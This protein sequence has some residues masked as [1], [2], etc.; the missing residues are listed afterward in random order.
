LNIVYNEVVKSLSGKLLRFSY[1][2]ALMLVF[3]FAL[4]DPQKLL[5]AVYLL[6][7]I[8]SLIIGLSI[9]LKVNQ[10]QEIRE[11]K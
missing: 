5:H 9:Y 6:G 4:T 2:E 10:K 7:G 11:R 3:K 1:Q 8:T